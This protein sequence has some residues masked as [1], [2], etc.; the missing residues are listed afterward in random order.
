MTISSIVI[1]TK[2]EHLENLISTINKSELCEYALHD[3]LGRIIITIEG[4][5]TG[6]EMQKLAEI[7]NFDHVISAEM[8]YSYNED[9]LEQMRSNLEISEP[10]EWLNDE[11]VKAEDI[12]YH[13]DLKK[14]KR[15]TF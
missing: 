1:Q 7:Q 11:N 4:K 5:D 8:H 10:P 9:E 14:K 12:E 13:G 15:R 6:D 3:D 2:P